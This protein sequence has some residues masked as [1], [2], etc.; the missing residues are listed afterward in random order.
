[1]QNRFAAWSI[2]QRISIV[3]RKRPQESINDNGVL[4]EAKTRSRSFEQESQTNGK[5]D[6]RAATADA[7]SV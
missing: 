3:L 7:T 1:M 5:N 6:S 4:P 2:S